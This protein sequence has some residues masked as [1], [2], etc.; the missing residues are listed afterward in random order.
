MQFIHT[1]NINIEFIKSIDKEIIHMPNNSYFNYSLFDT[2]FLYGKFP[3]TEF[4]RQ[5]QLT[6]IKLKNNNVFLYYDKKKKFHFLPIHHNKKKTFFINDQ[7]LVF[8]IKYLEHPVFILYIIDPD[9]YNIINYIVYTNH[10][11]T[12]KFD[13]NVNNATHFQFI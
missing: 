4:N 5:D 3:K 12:F 10:N 11:L 2:D 9:N 1:T 6:Y 7:P 13:T 8:W